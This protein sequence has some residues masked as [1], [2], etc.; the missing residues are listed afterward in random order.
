VVRLREEIQETLGRSQSNLVRRT[1]SQEDRVAALEEEVAHLRLVLAA[2][3]QLLMTKNVFNGEELARQA[4]EIVSAF[5]QEDGKLEGQL[6]EDG[7]V[8]PPPSPPPPP[9]TPLEELAKAI[10][11]PRGE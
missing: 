3:I 4:K 9:A 8:V 2:A 11:Q 1:I 6:R 7:Q 5:G 10:E